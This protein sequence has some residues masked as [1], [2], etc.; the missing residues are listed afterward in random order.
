MERKPEVPWPPWEP[1]PKPSVVKSFISLLGETVR[2]WNAHRVPRMGAALS[3]YMV[4][5]LAPLVI[6]TLSLVSI[7]VERTAARAGI[8]AQVR[9]QVGNEG[10][11]MVETIL[12][13][14]AAENTSIWGNVIGF[15]VLLIGAS[16]VFGELQ[17]SLNQIWEVSTK[18]HPIFLLIKERVI[19]FAMVFV[20]SLL[21]LIS[22]LFSAITAVAGGY[23]HG[24]S[25]GLDV[26]WVLGNPVLSL[27]VIA[28]LFALIYR[29]VPNARVTW[30]DVWLG[31]SIAAVLFV[32]GRFLL[33]FYFGHSTIASNYGAAG[34]L[35][36]ILAWVFYSAQILLLGAEF[37]H[38]YARRRGS[39][40]GTW[41][42]AR[43]A[44]HH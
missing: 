24:L 30:M 15:A 25:P 10:A 34:S 33:G 18:Q 7:A 4:F 39:L 22:F 40:Q 43:P 2:Q 42:T 28:L 31:A 44:S 13:R 23:L 37:T 9:A 36:I 12:G 35:I 20:M 1:S 38:V 14:T 16:G 11:D 21:M 5:S 8:V 41:D 32:L 26:V 29:V 3:F 19:S 17:D 6:L 27:L